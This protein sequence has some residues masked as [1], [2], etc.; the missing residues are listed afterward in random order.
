[1]EN[2]SALSKTFE[3]VADQGVEIQIP[4]SKLLYLTDRVDYGRVVL[5][6][7]ASSNLRQ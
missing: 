6:T 4:F 1:V 5:P 7:E 2:L 3:K